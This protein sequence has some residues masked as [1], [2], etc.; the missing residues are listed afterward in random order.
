MEWI[1]DYVADLDRRGVVATEPLPR[2]QDDWVE[3]VNTV[4]DL[5]LFPVTS[6]SAAPATWPARAVHRA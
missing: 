3:H 5:T 4:A 1:S 2:A 6:P